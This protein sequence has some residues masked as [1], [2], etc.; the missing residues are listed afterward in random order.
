MKKDELPHYANSHLLLRT[1]T[2]KSKLKFGE[3]PEL[4]VQEYFYIGNTRRLIE[5]YYG[6]GKINF[7]AEVLDVLKIYP[8]DQ[9]PKP[10]KLS[11]VER[12]E[13]VYEVYGRHLNFDDPLCLIKE[14]SRIMKTVKHNKMNSKNL[15]SIRAS[16]SYMASKNHGH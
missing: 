14:H 3:C 9:I 7:N 16:K 13:K 6:L 15:H 1:L 2:F 11:Y 12:K 10:G 4:T 5:M 8:E